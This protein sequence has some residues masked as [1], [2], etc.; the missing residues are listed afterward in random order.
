MGL[1]AVPIEAENKLTGESPMKITPLRVVVLLVVGVFAYGFYS[2][3]SREAAARQASKAAYA[4]AERGNPVLTIP[5]ELEMDSADK[6]AQI[7][8]CA[9]G[10]FSAK[11]KLCQGDGILFGVPGYVAVE[12]TEAGQLHSVTYMFSPPAKRLLL[13]KLAERFGPA[14]RFDSLGSTYPPH[15]WCWPL[16][17]G[18]EVVLENESPDDNNPEFAVYIESEVAGN[19]Y[20]HMEAIQGSCLS[21]P[22]L[23]FS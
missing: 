23:P 20:R 19:L 17:G 6:L 7:G 2:K 1:W 16:P 9:L 3:Y 13:Q 12:K 22:I 18:Q 11:H 8:D 5:A 14:H 4:Q 15:G 10:L 21:H